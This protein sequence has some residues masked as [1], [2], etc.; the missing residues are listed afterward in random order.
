MRTVVLLSVLTCSAL[1][2]ACT[3]DPTDPLPV[4][5][6]RVAAVE[7]LFP[8]L[9]QLHRDVRTGETVLQ[10]HPSDMQAPDLQGRMDAAA[11]ILGS[12][13]RLQVLNGPTR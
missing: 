10:I 3:H 11:Q 5:S 4:S 2:G 12:P 6:Q 7:H 8:S 1:L 9:Q 13:V